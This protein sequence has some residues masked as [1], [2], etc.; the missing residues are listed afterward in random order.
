MSKEQGL[1]S[2]SAVT[3]EPIDFRYWLLVAGIGCVAVVI[4]YC[5]AM[6]VISIIER[7]NHRRPLDIERFASG[8]KYGTL[9]RTSTFYQWNRRLPPPVLGKT[10]LNSKKPMSMGERPSSWKA[11]REELLKKYAASNDN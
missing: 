10:S 1:A 7:R 3:A 9:E 4:I 11:R 5:I 6:L 8:T 2:T